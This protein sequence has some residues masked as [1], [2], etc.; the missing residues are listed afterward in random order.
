MVKQEIK[1]DS[2]MLING[3]S[4]VWKGWKLLFLQSLNKFA[5]MTNSEMML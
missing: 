2:M 1:V 4:P 5:V 3:G